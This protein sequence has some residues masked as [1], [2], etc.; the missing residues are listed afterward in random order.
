MLIQAIQESLVEPL[1]AWR[2]EYLTDMQKAV[3]KYLDWAKDIEKPKGWQRD[4]GNVE[5]YL[6]AH[7]NDPSSKFA[8]ADPLFPFRTAGRITIDKAMPA[9]RQRAD[10]NVQ[11]V[12]DIVSQN[13]ALRLKDVAVPVTEAK[14]ISGRGINTTWAVTFEDGTRKGVDTQLVMAGGYNIQRLH[15]RYL[16]KVRDLPRL[17]EPQTEPEKA[18]VKA[19][20]ATIAGQTISTKTNRPCTAAW[21]ITKGKEIVK[22]GFSAT[23]ES[24]GIAARKVM[25]DYDFPGSTA[26]YASMVVDLD[27]AHAR[28]ERR[29]AFT[30]AV[31]E[32]KDMGDIEG[33]F[34][35]YTKK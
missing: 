32:A 31:R 35:K 25:K 3:Q 20:T 9:F 11:A 1:A 28:E 17:E 6:K 15:N 10:E 24:A 13:V 7:G 8:Q 27:P 2:E 29:A 12:K 34:E 22:F 14:L 26:S 30:Q 19:Y 33:A 21:A 4:P 18:Q 16:V 5:S 23:R